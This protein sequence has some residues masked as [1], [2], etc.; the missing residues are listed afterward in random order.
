M[1]T[2]PKP[3]L[4]IWRWRWCWYHWALKK[5]L[6]CSKLDLPGATVQRSRRDD[7]VKMAASGKRM[8][9]VTRWDG[10]RA[11]HSMIRAVHTR[12]IGVARKKNIR[13]YTSAQTRS[14]ISYH[15]HRPARRAAPRLP[16]CTQTWTPN[17]TKKRRSSIYIF[18]FYSP[19]W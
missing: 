3:F 7:F 17:A 14:L 13:V 8:R 1:Y 4:P 18:I 19:N 2:L 11:T 16:P 12:C 15:T 9:T 10:R 5:S 6:A